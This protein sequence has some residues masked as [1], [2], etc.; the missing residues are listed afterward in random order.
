MAVAAQADAWLAAWAALQLARLDADAMQRGSFYVRALRHPSAHQVVSGFASADDFNG[1]A[2]SAAA[3]EAMDE[4]AEAV[5][6]ERGA[7]RP[8]SSTLTAQQQRIAS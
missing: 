5:A 8:T 3:A 4:A 6:A 2:E 7:S 1:L